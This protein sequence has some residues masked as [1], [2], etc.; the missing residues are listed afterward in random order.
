M[1][2]TI[3]L[4]L[5]LICLLFLAGCGSTSNY[6]PQQNYQQQAERSSPYCG[7]GSCN[8]DENC[9]T[10]PSDCGKCVSCYQWKQ[11]LTEEGRGRIV[12][13]DGECYPFYEGIGEI[14]ECLQDCA[15]VE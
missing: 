14:C 10:C 13:G 7:D 15:A 11:T 12:C 1:R 6:Q 8:S 2:K 4:G 5:G 9:D 3:I